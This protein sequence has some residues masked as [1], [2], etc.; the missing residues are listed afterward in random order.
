MSFYFRSFFQ[1][2]IAFL[3]KSQ[4]LEPLIWLMVRFYKKI[5]K[6]STIIIIILTLLFAGIIISRTSDIYAGE[7]FK[8]HVDDVVTVRFSPDG[9]ILASGSEDT[10]IKLWDVKTGEL[11]MTLKGH[12]DDVSS[13]EFSPDGKYLVSASCDQTVRIWDLKNGTT[14]KILGQVP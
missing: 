1:I 11:L 12:S 4:V 10:T 9:N 14:I 2:C 13:I 6:N 7:N 5:M 3:R 8:G